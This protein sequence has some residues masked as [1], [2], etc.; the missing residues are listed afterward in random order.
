LILPTTHVTLT[1]FWH[2]QEAE[3]A[4]KG[5][6]IV[7][8]LVVDDTSVMRFILIDILMRQYGVE[9]SDIYEAENGRE[10]LNKY[11]LFKPDVIFLDITMPDLD[12][13]TVVK[14]L[15]A[16]DSR[17]KIIMFTSSNDEADVVECIQAGARDYIV[18][19]PDP[20][21]VL[22]AV[23]KATGKKLFGL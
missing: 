4:R 1:F 18:K 21:R 3:L 22:K 15:M 7:T 8:F 23:E 19:P 5:T 11:R 9:K 10:A 14:E 6:T 12:G 13:I 20:E 16:Q 2:W 17:I